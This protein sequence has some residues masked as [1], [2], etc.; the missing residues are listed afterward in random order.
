MGIRN[1]DKLNTL[2]QLIPE[3]IAVPSTWLTAN[4]YSPQLVRKYVQSGWLKALGSRVYARPGEPVTWEGVIVGLQR[5]GRL[6]LYIGGITSLNRQGLAHYLSLGGDATVHVWGQEKPPAWVEQVPVGAKWSFHRRRLFT[7]DLEQGWVA[8]PTRMRDWTLRV[9]APER[10]IL[11]VL[12]EMDDTPSA[13][14]FAAELFE[15]LTSLRPAVVNALLQSCVH[16]KAKRLFLFLADHYGYPWAKRI[17]VDAIDLGRG[18][19]LITRGG[20][21]DKRYQITV[22]EAFHVGSE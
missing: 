10:A 19:R 3:G 14:S 21:L 5:L 7:H 6:Q 16:N 17:D 4:G 11:E 20:K 12:S 1:N 9:S 22:P 2:Q 18:K 13:F 15:G 8:L